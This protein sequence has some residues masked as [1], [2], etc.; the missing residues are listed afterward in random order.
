MQREQ[1]I[2]V[3]LSWSSMSEPPPDPWY[4]S[5]STLNQAPSIL[6]EVVSP[7]GMAKFDAE[8]S[9]ATIPLILIEP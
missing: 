4:G 8:R 7:S 3:P 9:T 1:Q 2:W 6:I 5:V